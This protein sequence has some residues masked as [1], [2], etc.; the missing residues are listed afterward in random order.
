MPKRTRDIYLYLPY[1][2][3]NIFPTVAVFGNLD[4]LSGNAKRKIAFYPTSVMRSDKGLI[5]LRN[6]II[7]DSQK[8]EV[9]IGQQ[10]KSVKNFVITEN[11]KDGK[12]QL[13][14]QLYHMD[15][16]YCVIY[17][18]SYGQFVVMDSEIFHSTYVQM[19]ILGKYN[20]DLF[21]LVVSSPYSKIYKLKR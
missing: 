21:E 17:M 15:G 1:R 6:G 4:L 14:S 18:K 12:I 7:F 3:M 5:A 13:Q 10:K 2:M 16:E 19:F 9:T 20:A 8:G 11:T